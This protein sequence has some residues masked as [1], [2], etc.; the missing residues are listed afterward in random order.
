MAGVPDGL[1]DA[2]LIGDVETQP[3]VDGEIGQGFRPACGG[4][5]AVTAFRER[6][7]DGSADAL[8]GAGDEY[9]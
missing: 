9:G 4:D 2:L 3:L 7:G 1:V 5:H 8:G 6:D